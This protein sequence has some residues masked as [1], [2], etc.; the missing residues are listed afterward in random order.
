[1]FDSYIVWRSTRYKRVDYQPDACDYDQHTCQA[2]LL[3]PGLG[4]LRFH[5]FEGIAAFFQLPHE[6]NIEGDEESRGDNA[7][8]DQSKEAVH[9]QSPER[10]EQLLRYSLLRR[11]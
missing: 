1:M 2:V 7:Q 5:P 8:S 11:W 9:L 4:T 6:I 10:V 3:F